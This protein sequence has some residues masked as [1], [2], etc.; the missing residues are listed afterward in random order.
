[1]KKLGFRLLTSFFGIAALTSIISVS[2]ISCSDS[3]ISSNQNNSQT[4]SKDTKPS[5]DKDNNLKNTSQK[6]DLKTIFPSKKVVEDKNNIKALDAI[7]MIDSLDTLYDFYTKPNDIPQNYEINFYKSE[8]YNN[9]ENSVKVTLKVKQFSNND[10]SEIS[11]LIYGFLAYSDADYLLIFIDANRDAQAKETFDNQD[12]SMIDPRFLSNDESSK[13]FFKNYYQAVIP[14]TLENNDVIAK[15]VS[16]KV[17]DNYSVAYN[18]QLIKE[19]QKNDQSHIIGYPTINVNGF[20]GYKEYVP[21][22][23]VKTDWKPNNDQFIR[24]HITNLTNKKDFDHFIVN[25]W[26][27]SLANDALN[28][29][30]WVYTDIEGQKILTNNLKEYIKEGWNAGGLIHWTIGYLMGY[31]DSGAAKGL[32]PTY[33]SD[34]SLQS[35]G[36][37]RLTLGWYQKQYYQRTSGGN[38]TADVNG[39]VYFDVS[40]SIKPSINSTNGNAQILNTQIEGIINNEAPG[41]RPTVHDGVNVTINILDALYYYYNQI[42]SD[43]INIKNQMFE[44]TKNSEVPEYSKNFYYLFKPLFKIIDGD[45]KFAFRKYK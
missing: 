35:N 5:D 10:T 14:E 12:V 16:F 22:A 7:N 4:G 6:I 3:G 40:P 11:F 32:N 9:F 13:Y 1:M 25:H 24:H 26:N 29:I 27:Q 34:V 8:V 39:S 33:T 2:A 19:D 43:G 15:L 41:Y 18:Y 20:Y 45:K 44:I 28:A 21:Y 31:N 36:D 38:Y 37:L 30:R 42:F 23:P 17:N